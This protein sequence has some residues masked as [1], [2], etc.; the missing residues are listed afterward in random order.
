M[1]LLLFTLCPLTGWGTQ[2]YSYDNLN[3]LEGL[4]TAG[5]F[6]NTGF[7]LRDVSGYNSSGFS[8]NRSRMSWLHSIE[9]PNE[10]T[11]SFYTARFDYD[12]DAQRIRMRMYNNGGTS[13]LHYTHCYPSDNTEL[14]RDRNGNFTWNYYA[15]GDYYTAKAVQRAHTTGSDTLYQIYRDNLGSVVMY[16]SHTGSSYRFRYSPWG[17]RLTGAGSET[18]CTLGQ[19]PAGPFTRTYTGHEELW[20]F[21][22]LNANARLYNPYI[23]RFISA[24]AGALSSVGLGAIGIG[25]TG[26]FVGFANGAI[27]GAGSNLIQAGMNYAFLGVPYSY[28]WKE[29][30]MQTAISGAIG[31]ITGGI[32]AR[33]DGNNFWTGKH[34]PVQT[35][36]KQAQTVINSNVLPDND[37][38]AKEMRNLG[39]PEESINVTCEVFDEAKAIPGFGKESGT[40]SVYLGISENNIK[41]VGITKRDPFIRAMEHKRSMSINSRL[42]FKPLP[43]TGSLSTVDSRRI[44]QLFINQDRPKKMLILNNRR[45]SIAPK[46]W[47]KFGLFKQ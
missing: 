10:L 4:P 5:T 33:M 34:I 41:Y 21:G 25:G 22:L 28:D 47:K 18:S 19:C 36:T 13:Y 43:G 20:Q 14:I 16:A 45:N 23:G 15:G 40:S 42:N 24:A 8:L 6:H 2:S 3:N 44:E 17:T 31:G 26:F 12:G 30:L 9:R 29:F 46:F 11:D 27:T 7:R 1:W 32:Q 39:F 37:Y 35:S 38:I